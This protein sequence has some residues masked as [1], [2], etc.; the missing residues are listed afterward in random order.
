MEPLS[1]VVLWASLVLPATVIQNWPT[2]KT[3]KNETVTTSIIS[4]YYVRDSGV[5]TSSIVEPIALEENVN[6]VVNISND[7][8]SQLNSYFELKSGWDGPDSSPPA[9]TDIESAINFANLIP[10]IFPMPKA[11][12]SSDGEVGLY[13]DDNIAYID[14]QFESDQTLS[15]FSRDRSSGKETFIEADITT[16]DS[17]WF[18]DTF[19]ELLRLSGYGLA[20]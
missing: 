4:N 2:E 12:L 1:T 11:M 13:W 15:I 7:V 6:V 14:L 19:G 16:I 10:P 3:K 18:F 8:F 20:A 17:E 9:S 5:K